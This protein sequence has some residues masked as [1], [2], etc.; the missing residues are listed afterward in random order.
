VVRLSLSKTI[1]HARIIVSD[2]GPG[3]RADDLPH[4]FERFYRSEKSRHR[5]RND[6]GFGLGLSIAY[7][8]VRNHGG[9]ID[10][11]SK[12]GAG[13]TFCVWLPLEGPKV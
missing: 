2:D 7:W 9:R 4:I 3:I 8:I 12:E 6:S 10:V 1:T 11:D 13:T 5:A